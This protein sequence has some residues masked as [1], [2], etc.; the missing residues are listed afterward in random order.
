MSSSAF[1]ITQRTATHQ[2][3]ANLQRSLERM[4]SIQE[5]LSSGKQVSRPSDAPVK[6]VDS[7]AFRA[8]INRTQQFTRNAEDGLGWLGLADSTVSTISERLIRVR[9]LLLRGLSGASS[10]TD[11][12]ALAAEVEQIRDNV[13]NLANTTYLNR[14]LFAGTADVGAA[15]D[16]LGVF[17]GDT[18]S[19]DRSVAPGVTVR[20]NLTGPELFETG[21]TDLFTNLTDIANDLRTNPANLS[22]VDLPEFNALVDN[23]HNRLGEVGAR[24]NR[25]EAVRRRS[26]EQ[27][28]VLRR[29]LSEAEDIDLA[30]TIV[31]LQLQEVS[32]QAALGATARVITPSL[33]DFLR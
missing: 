13:V 1:R 15:Y 4:Q 26:D 32:Y 20:V 17:Q 24:F 25:V 23:L 22:A 21:G 19:I 2:T 9:E 3:M 5:Q 6:T 11:R 31:D 27:L 8:E 7:L 18:G 33:V 29:S 30:S 10:T 14:P 28:L 16:A 12:A